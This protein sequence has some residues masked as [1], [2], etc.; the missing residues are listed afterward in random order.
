VISIAAWDIIITSPDLPDHKILTINIYTQ[1][2][3]RSHSFL[4]IRQKQ[5]FQR[6]KKLDL[7]GSNDT[8]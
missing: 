3:R 2:V 8:H 5:N 6:V 7:R 1:Q 4:I